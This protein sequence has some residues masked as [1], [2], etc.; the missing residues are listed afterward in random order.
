MRP[1]PPAFIA[2]KHHAALQIL[3]GEPLDPVDVQNM[4]F[5]R[6]H[7][8]RALEAIGR[9]WPSVLDEDFPAPSA[10]ETGLKYEV[11]RQQ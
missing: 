2:F 3:R 5:T 8:I 4:Q 11:V 6:S 9:A 7:A 10:T 1:N